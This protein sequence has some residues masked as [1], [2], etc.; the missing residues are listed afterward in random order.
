MVKWLPWLPCKRDF[1]NSTVLET[2]KDIPNTLPSLKLLEQR[3]HELVGG[4]GGGPLNS[5]LDNVVGSKRLRSGRVKIRDTCMTLLSYRDS[6]EEM[7]VH[8]WQTL[9]N[10]TKCYSVTVESDKFEINEIE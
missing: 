1:N 4:G 3:I 5:P 8:V 9:F 10:Y 6:C 7:N 2:Y